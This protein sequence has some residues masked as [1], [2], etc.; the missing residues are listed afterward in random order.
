VKRVPSAPVTSAILD[1]LAPFGVTNL[2]GPATP[3]RIWRA[4]KGSAAET[5]GAQS[6]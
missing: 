2:A 5:M 4:M 1:V 3:E 6:R